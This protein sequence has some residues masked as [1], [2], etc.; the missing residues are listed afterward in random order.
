MWWRRKRQ[1][2]SANVSS[3]SSGSSGSSGHKHSSKHTPGDRFRWIQGRRYVE[4][5]AYIGPKDASADQFLD[6]QHYLVRRILGG[7]HQAPLQNPRMILDVGCGTGRWAVEM[8]AEFPGLRV[9]ALDL[10][11]PDRADAILAP[12][13]PLAANVAFV[14]VDARQ[15]LPFVDGS[16]DHAHLRLLYSELPGASYPALI[17]ELARVVRPGGWVECIEPGETVYDPGP[18]YLL[19]NR[20]IGELCRSRG[21][22]PDLGPKLKYL[23]RDAGLVQVTERAVPSFPDVT[24]T[25]ERRLWLA[26]ALGVLQG[27]FRDPIIAAGIASQTE[28]D[29]A[30][31]ALRDEFEQGRYANSDLLFVALG[32]RPSAAGTSQA[33]SHSATA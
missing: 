21:L 17:R 2:T 13:G 31:V 5:T 28:Y 16:F 6:F 20:W 1:A 32:Q 26:Q 29:N 8:A 27:V 25:R 12:L 4:G 7:N 14:E 3:S 23:L 18:A 24:L 22:D 19:T 30:L 11:Q 10:V 9:V 33:A 15:G